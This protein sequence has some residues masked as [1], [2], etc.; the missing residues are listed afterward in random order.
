MGFGTAMKTAVFA[1]MLAKPFSLLGQE[2]G[3][4]PTR[5]DTSLA[6]RVQRLEDIEE[7]RNVLID[8]GRYLDSR[9]FAAYSG[10]FANDGEW[11]GGFGVVRGPAAIQAFMEKNITGPNRGN[12]FHLLTNFEVVVHG[13][14]LVCSV[15]GMVA[16]D[17]PRASVEIALE[18]CLEL[19]EARVGGLAALRGFTRSER[20][21][22]GALRVL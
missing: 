3:K 21:L 2:P 12:T 6:A 4:Q 22:P 11:A 16:P 1:I 18:V 14:D 7:I 10:L 9:D 5:N 17:P 15:P 19:A 8:Y 20:A 13:D